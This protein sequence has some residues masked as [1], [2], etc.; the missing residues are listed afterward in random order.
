M[1]THARHT[2]SFN[3]KWNFQGPILS[4]ISPKSVQKRFLENPICR[5]KF[6][7]ILDD[8]VDTYYT[9]T[10]ESVRHMHM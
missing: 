7:F 5:W 9:H 10:C 8:E 6:H 4:Q 2:T 1:H 3:L